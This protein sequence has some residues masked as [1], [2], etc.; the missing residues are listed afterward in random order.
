MRM[1]AYYSLSAETEL[2]LLLHAPRQ[3]TCN[4]LPFC[5]LPQGGLVADNNT[6][7]GRV[8]NRRD[9]VTIPHFQFQE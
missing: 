3:L 1:V 5:H 7:E 2:V 8:K 9:E 6:A 4:K